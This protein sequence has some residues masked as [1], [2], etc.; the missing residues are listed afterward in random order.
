MTTK[1]KRRLPPA[2]LTLAV[3]TLL[4]FPAHYA[5]FEIWKIAGELNNP[6][7]RIG[8]VPL[9]ALATGLILSF[10]PT[11]FWEDRQPDSMLGENRPAGRKNPFYGSFFSLH[12]TKSCEEPRFSNTASSA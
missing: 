6:G 11:T 7:L 4:I 12:G 9:A 1:A 8:S 3:G 5:A 2:R 10:S